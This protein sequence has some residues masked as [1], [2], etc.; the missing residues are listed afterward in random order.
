MA[1]GIDWF[2]WHHGSVTDPK[3]ALVARK[4]SARLGDVVAVW[5]F[6]LEAASASRD[7]GHFGEVDAEAVDCLLGAEDGTCTAILRAMEDRGLIADGAVCA[8]EK[9]QPKRER[10]DDSSTDRVRAFRDRK[11]HETPSNATKRQETPRGEESREEK[12]EQELEATIPDGMVVRREPADP[13]STVVAPTQ[14]DPVPHAEIVAAYHEELPMLPKVKQ[15]SARRRAI[16]RTRWR[17]DKERQSIEWWRGFFRY[18]A[19]CPFLVG[20][21]S[22]PGRDPFL[23][24]IEWLLAPKNFF[25]VIEGKYEGRGAA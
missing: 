9:R 23:A 5:A 3:F 11:R 8:W 19:G 7:R 22:S 10:D 14:I 21:R 25:A 1:H 15:W 24:D 4:A 20:Q 2:R 12:K 17:E 18:V 16:L 6:V 13:P